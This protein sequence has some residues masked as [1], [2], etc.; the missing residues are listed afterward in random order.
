MDTHESTGLDEEAPQGGNPSEP[1][2]GLDVWLQRVE[3]IGELHTVAAEVDPELE[4]STIAHLC[5]GEADSPALLFDNIKGHPGHRALWGNIAG[6]LNRFCVTIREAP[7]TDAIAVVNVLKDKMKRRIPPRVVDAA[8]A[9][10]NRNIDSGEAL[11]ITKFPSPLM[12][13]LDGG[14]YIGTG[15]AII[16]RDPETGRVN[17]GTYRQMVTSPNEVGFWASPGKDALLHREAWWA[18]GKPAPV[19]CV[20][21]LD[22]LL[23]MVGSTNFPKNVCE[24]D[25]FGG[26]NGAGIEVFESDVTGLPLPA[27]AEIIC[28][29]F[30][31]P[32]HTAPEGPFGEFTGYYGAP[33]TDL[34]FITFTNVRYRDNPVLVCAL[35][36]HGRSNEC[37]VPWSVSRS[38]KI[39]EDLERLGVPGI[40]GVWSPPEAAGAGMT[41]VSIKQMY[42]GHAPQTLALA[43]QCMGGASFTKYVVVVDDDVDPTDL[44]DV[45]WAMITRSR[46]A[47]SIEILRETWSNPLDPSLNPPEIRPWGSKCLINACMEHR[48][49]GS[50]AT[51]TKLSQPV[52][53]Q[54]A[55]RWNELGFEGEAP[56][57]EL[58][59]T[60]TSVSA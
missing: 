44:S 56:K 39:W 14:K 16:T 28:E 2:D 43:A 53:E 42:A 24:Y 40:K 13:P 38:A 49:L 8:T 34:P 57:V 17:V 46:P 47:Q 27:N 10:V 30:A 19:A 22:P 37:G 5:G 55:A 21:G 31:Y 45:V 9:P 50:F 3:A 35:M 23:L 51:R 20:Y 15:D 29:G 6:S 4:M 25:A 7:S 54:V 1:M 48:Y 26:I 11:D 32:E 18:R 33:R 12:W 52:Y 58:F 60:E 36:A 41:V 59:Q